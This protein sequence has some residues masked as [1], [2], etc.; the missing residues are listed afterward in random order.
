MAALERFYCT[1][2]VSVVPSEEPDDS[3]GQA[4]PANEGLKKPAEGSL[5]KP[6]VGQQELVV[7]M[8]AQ[9]A[10]GLVN[11]CECDKPRMYYSRTKLTFA[12]STLI[13]KCISEYIFTC[14]APIVDPRYKSL[15][16]VVTRKLNCGNPVEVCYYASKFGDG[17]DI[18]C[19]CGYS[20]GIVIHFSQMGKTDLSF[21]FKAVSTTP[22]L[23]PQ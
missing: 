19:Y 23:Y 22:P 18:C 14:G 16:G 12:Q 11:C 3:V 20:G 2:F 15:R 1:Y 10:R 17:S 4:I 6:T 13:A 9:T 8:T 7:S 5:K 21:A